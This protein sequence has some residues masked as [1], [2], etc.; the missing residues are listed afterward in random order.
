MTLSTGSN[1][2][3]I[4]NLKLWSWSFVYVSESIQRIW[5]PCAT[6][7]FWD[8]IMNTSH[9]SHTYNCNASACVKRTNNDKKILWC[10]HCFSLLYVLIIL[11]EEKGL[12]VF[13]PASPQ[14]WSTP[15]DRLYREESERRRRKPWGLVTGTAWKQP[16]AVELALWWGGWMDGGADGRMGGWVGGCK[17]WF[18]KLGIKWKRTS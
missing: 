18:E 9:I 11:V 4:R 14:T 3:A 12:F 13:L 5:N 2:H 16:P 6:A 1:K 15:L 7:L 17:I 10:V 8:D